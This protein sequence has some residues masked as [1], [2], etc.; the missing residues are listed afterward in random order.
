MISNKTITAS[1]FSI[2]TGQFWCLEVTFDVSSHQFSSLYHL[3]DSIQVLVLARVKVLPA[4][5]NLF[6]MCQTLFNI[7]CSENIDFSNS[8]IIVRNQAISR[9]ESRWKMSIIIRIP[10]CFYFLDT[11]HYILNLSFKYSLLQIETKN[12]SVNL[13]K[14]S[15]KFDVV[16]LVPKLW[17]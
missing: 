16:C 5:F 6:R 11:N 12:F 4:L 7:K 14:H 9:K 13:K 10:K 8:L 1:T 3:T 15:I 17:Y 2:Q